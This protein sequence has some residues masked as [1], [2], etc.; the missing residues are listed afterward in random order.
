MPCAA[1]IAKPWPRSRESAGGALD[2]RLGG[3]SVGAEDA[4]LVAAHPV[5]RAAAPDEEAELLAEPAQQHVAGRMA[6][7]V[8]VL[9]EPV[10]VEEREDARRPGFER[11]FEVVEQL[12]PV[13]ESGERSVLASWREPTSIC[14]FSAK[15]IARRTMTARIAAV[16]ITSESG[17]T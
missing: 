17:L 13:A 7:R 8:V 4:E 6:E 3:E 16:A 9:L 15:V 14:L 10:E 11:F 5:G 2:G 1:V 12:A